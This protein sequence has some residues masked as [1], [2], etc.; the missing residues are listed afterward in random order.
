MQISSIRSA[1]PFAGYGRKVNNQSRIH[2]LHQE[3]ARVQAASEGFNASLSGD[4]ARELELR[5]EKELILGKLPALQWATEGCN[6]GLSSRDL[7]RLD[8][9]D[10]E[11]DA[12]TP[13][14]IACD[15][16][17]CETARTGY[18]DNRSE[19]IRYWNW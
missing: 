4:A 15:C 18:V 5:R 19:D 11:L 16:P 14:P 8:E 6:G 17:R 7:A 2:E 1:M 13:E 3:H 9:I 10:E 12:I